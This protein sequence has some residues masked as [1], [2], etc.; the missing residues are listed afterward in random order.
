[1]NA[2]LAIGKGI[3]KYELPRGAYIVVNR[4]LKNGKLDDIPISDSELL[5]LIAIG[6]RYLATKLRA[7]TR[8]DGKI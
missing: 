5:E 8:Q 3:D 1:M 6:S 7:E 4:N 2:W